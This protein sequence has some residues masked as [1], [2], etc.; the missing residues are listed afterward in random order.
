MTQL[1]NEVVS[2]KHA[3]TASDNKTEETAVEQSVTAADGAQKEKE[4]VKAKH[5]E[6]GVCCG[7]CS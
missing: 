5:G 6:N 1:F 7:G 3:G 4:A 2:P